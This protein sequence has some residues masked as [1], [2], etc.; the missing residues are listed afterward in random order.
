MT[1]TKQKAAIRVAASL[2]MVLAILLTFSFAG[3][4]LTPLV[5]GTDPAQSTPTS[6]Q[7]LANT[8]PNPPAPVLPDYLHPLT[9]LE[10]TEALAGTRPISVCLGNTSAD[11][12]P[13]FGIGRAELLFEVPVEG[14]ITRLMMVTTDYKSLDKIGSVRSTRLSLARLA[15]GMDAI[16]MYAGTCDEGASS[17]LSYDTLD[18]LMQNLP[19]IYYRDSERKAPYNLMT[20]G[21]LAASGI[22]A[23]NYRT[24]L[25]ETFALPFSFAE[26]GETVMP[27]DDTALSVRMAYSYVNVVT[28]TYSQTAH[29]YERTQFG[30]L[31]KDASGQTLQFE[32]LFI[33]NANTI[34]YESADGSTLELSLDEGGTGIWCSEG[35]QQEIRWSIGEDDR[36]CFTDANG[37]PLTVNR[38]TSYIGFVKASQTGAV[39]V[40]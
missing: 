25:S 15:N 36:L 18:Y 20:S 34:T 32:N 30:T 37:N 26:Y 24:T 17:L 33:L 1:H 39:T 9:G 16:Q 19:N 31:Q 6:S 10:T 8:D 40:Q 22:S 27:A 12:T 28:F 38:G 5:N 4:N 29:A 3:C 11:D 2:M 23:F 21:S 13:Q 14:G 35:M 7:P